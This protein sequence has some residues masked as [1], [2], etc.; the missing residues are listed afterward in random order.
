MTIR[1]FTS[2]D[3]KTAE[4]AVVRWVLPRRYKLTVF[5]LVILITMSTK[6]IPYIN[7]VSNA[8][9]RW[10]FILVSAPLI[11]DIDPRYFFIFGVTCFFLTAVLWFIGQTEEAEIL[12]DYIFIV[13]LSGAI[14]AFFSSKETQK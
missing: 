2:S 1:N 11:L 7:L 10:L 6:Y 5:F 14:K 13:L 4:K 9:V 3:I 8:Y 12:A